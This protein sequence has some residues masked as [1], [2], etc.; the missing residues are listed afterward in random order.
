MGFWERLGLGSERPQRDWVS[1]ADGDASFESD[2]GSVRVWRFPDGDAVGIY[3]FDLQPDLP[4]E[5]DL[6]DFVSKTRDHVTATGATLV[7]CSILGIR[8]I[9]AVRQIVKVRQDPSGLTYLG[10]LTLPFRNFSYVL[11]VQC[12]ERGV[13][14]VREAILLDEALAAKTVEIVPDSP[15][16]IRGDWNPDSERHDARFPDHPV[17]RVRKHLRSLA[18]ACQVNEALTKHPFFELPV[19]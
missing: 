6:T 11:K 3:F 14:G 16:P 2:T 15:N 19:A 7:E 9:R 4:R 18:A 1:L 17:S 10:S 12:E 13:T 5:L 8:A